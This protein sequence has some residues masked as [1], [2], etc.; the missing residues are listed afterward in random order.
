MGSLNKMVQEYLQGAV[1][2]M[3][4]ATVRSGKPWIA[5]VYFVAD[6][7]LNVY[8]LSWPERRHSRELMENTSVAGAIVVKTDQPVI[9]IQFTGFAKE[10]TNLNTVKRVMKLYVAKYNK[11]EKFYDAAK[12]GLNKHHMYKLVPQEISLFDEVT[13]PNQSPVEVL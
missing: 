2:T 12:S 8:W 10:V 5:T 6:D 9:G 13:Y 3:Q 7:E 11:G 4:L 1:P